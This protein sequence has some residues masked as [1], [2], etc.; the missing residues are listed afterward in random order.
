MI[1][2]RKKWV[3]LKFADR[4]LL[5]HA[6]PNLVPS[7]PEAFK[8]PAHIAERK[9][10]VD[11]ASVPIDTLVEVKTSDGWMKRYFAGYENGS[12]CYWSFG[13]TSVTVGNAYNSKALAVEM[14]LANDEN[15]K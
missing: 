3:I 11:W 9:K 6:P 8:V 1:Y 2:Q 7:N 15:T 13:A 14:R 12:C 4:Q 10:T 5:F